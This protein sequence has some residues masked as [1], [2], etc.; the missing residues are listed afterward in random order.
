M[1]TMKIKPVILLVFAALLFVTSC[2]PAEQTGADT[3]MVPSATLTFTPDLCS[4]ENIKTEVEK[5][6]R[7]MREFDD[8][9]LLAANMPREQLHDSIA[10][11]QQIRRKA[12]DEKV[13]ICLAK[14]KQSQLTHMNTVITTL[15]SFMGN[16]DQET[17]TQG[18]QTARQQH[19][20]YYLEMARL[21]GVTV[22]PATIM[23]AAEQTQPAP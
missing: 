9:S 22:V 13:P 21:L 18:I 20:E 15:V 11:L 23:P 1:C 5:V 7:L 2:G 19:D 12:E 8:A 4:P 16:G 3:S 10:G 17:I 14:L 6:H